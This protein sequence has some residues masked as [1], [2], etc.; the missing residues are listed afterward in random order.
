ME[1]QEY[2][3]TAALGGSSPDSEKMSELAERLKELRELKTAAEQRLQE[4]NDK[5]DETDYRLSELMA[6]SETQNFTRGGVMFYLV[7]KTRASAVAGRKKELF[8]TLRSEG[9][10]EL[11]TETVNANS[12]SSF[13]KERIEENEDILPGWLSGLVNVFEKTSVGVRKALK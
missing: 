5:I 8:A 4:I 2:R 13:V 1:S 11:V 7:T 3:E 9:F 10:G 6:E 12:L